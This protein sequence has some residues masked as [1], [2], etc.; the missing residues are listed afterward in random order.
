MASKSSKGGPSSGPPR[1]DFGAGKDGLSK[2][3]FSG[4]GGPSKG[5]FGKPPMPDMPEEWGGKQAMRKGGKG[6]PMEDDGDSWD[7]PSQS[8]AAMGPPKQR[9]QGKGK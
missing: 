2:D 9:G 1:P 3:M 6:P 7:W 8:K 4:K 5:N